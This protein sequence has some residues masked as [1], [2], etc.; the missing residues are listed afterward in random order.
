MRSG[1]KQTPT[2]FVPS[3]FHC[4]LVA[5]SCPTLCNPMDCSPPGSSAHGDSPGRRTGVGC[6]SLSRGS[7][8]ARDQTQV[9]LGR[10]SLY[11]RVQLLTVV[12]RVPVC[13]GKAC[14]GAAENSL[15]HNLCANT[16]LGVGMVVQSQGSQSEG[17]AEWGQ[18]GEEKTQVGHYP[19]GHSLRLCLTT[20]PGNKGFPGGSEGKESACQCRRPRFDLGRSG[21]HIN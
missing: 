3:C 13:W 17:E 21:G 15:Q 19:A 10:R 7:S 11:P 2:Q 4:C 8:P 16:F 14:P 5:K 12:L 1:Y 18:K 6:H 9:R 20:A